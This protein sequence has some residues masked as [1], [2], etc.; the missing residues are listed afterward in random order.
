[1]LK[2]NLVYIIIGT[3]TFALILFLEYNKKEEINW[4]PS[5][6]THHK[7]PFG[8]K[9]LSD[10]I[11][12]KF[13]SI[14]EVERPPFE[15]LKNNSDT[16]STYLFVN[17]SVSF[18]DDEL[19]DLLEWTA[20]GNTLFIAS[21]NFEDSLLDTLGLATESLFGD[22]GLA[23]EFQHKLVNPNLALKRNFSY[24][25][26]Y[27]TMYFSALD[28]LNS[29][30]V[31]E[32]SN[33]SDEN[34]DFEIHPSIIKQDFGAGTLILSTFPIAFTN[35]FIL[36]DENSA[37]TAGLLSYLDWEQPLYIDTY[38]KSGKKFY[39]SPMY[40][41]LNTKE[42]KWAYYLILIGVLLYVIFE[43][44]RKQRAIPVVNP[45][46]NQSL[47]FTRTIA[48]MYFEKGERSA[49]ANH[50]IAY[51][52]EEIRTNFYLNTETQNEEFYKNLAARSHHSFEEIEALFNLIN[53]V[54]NKTILTDDALIALN[55]SLEKFKAK[56]HGK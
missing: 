20:K 2:K 25:K 22:E 14:Q 11:Q 54:K 15:F 10:I 56:A 21:S 39:T 42:L 13:K 30:V 28:T 49:I 35:Y 26:S 19:A 53:S 38:Y 1:M 3:L 32:V 6:V 51:F 55:S 50:K 16:T 29:I 48:D 41:F 44:K 27:S 24:E 8:T 23:H 43:G 40:I 12:T 18:G 36:K 47:A 37:Y 17:N 9:V 33:A 34:N 46:V 7:I 45:L 31:G 52:L 5:Y 4:F